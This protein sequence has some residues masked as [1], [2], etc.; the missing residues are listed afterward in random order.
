MADFSLSEFTSQLRGMLYDNFPYENEYENEKKHKNRSG[1]IRD[2]AFKNN[3]TNVFDQNHLEFDIGN[4][5]AEERYPYYHILQDA[6]YIR[7]RGK[8]TKKSGGSQAQISDA[9]ARNYGIVSWNGKTYS[10]EYAKNVRG[11]RNRDWKVRR[12][13][14]GTTINKNSNE[15]LNIHYGYIDK[16]LDT[17]TDLLSMMFGIKKI[18]KQNTGLQDD[19]S[20]S[21]NIDVLPLSSYDI[22]DIF[23][24]L[25]DYDDEGEE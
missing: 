4:E 1:H 7:I 3:P 14:G 8:A 24:S 11:A 13:I 9:R 25:G 15:Y 12:S 17:I 23:N 21:R 20:L 19:Y 22:I 5:L 6:P 2:V 16:K 10:K 18:R